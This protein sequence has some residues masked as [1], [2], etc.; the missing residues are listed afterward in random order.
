MD[1]IAYM[2]FPRRRPLNWRQQF[3]G[4]NHGLD[5]LDEDEAIIEFRKKMELN[6][7]QQR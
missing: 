2:L 6:H 5:S 7:A 4:I 1:P 3:L